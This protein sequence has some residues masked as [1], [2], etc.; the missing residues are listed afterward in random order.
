MNILTDKYIIGGI[1]TTYEIVNE[2]GL[3]I[4]HMDFKK[5]QA[6]KAKVIHLF[7]DKPDKADILLEMGWI[8]DFDYIGMGYPVSDFIKGLHHFGPQQAHIEFYITPP[9]DIL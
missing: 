9:I 6:I 1:T 8:K 4:G 7:D 2:S 3:R 5:N